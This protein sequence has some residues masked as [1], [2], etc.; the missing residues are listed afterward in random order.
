MQALRDG[1]KISGGWYAR[2]YIHP[3][4][5]VTSRD[6]VLGSKLRFR[7]R[8][9]WPG[10]NEGP[11]LFFDV[12]EALSHS[13]AVK[14][15]SQALDKIEVTAMRGPGMVGTV[16]GDMVYHNGYATQGVHRAQA[17]ACWQDAVNRYH[18]G[19]A[20]DGAPAARRRLAAA[21]TGKGRR[22]NACLRSARAVLAG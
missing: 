18:A 17:L 5:L 14:Y 12:G 4:Y 20:K 6:L 2:N 11:M 1:A 22:R 7:T 19:L 9:R 10:E 15:G 8:G 13:T 16:Y 21:T 3:S